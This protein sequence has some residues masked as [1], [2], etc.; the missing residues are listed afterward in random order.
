MPER[1]D[2]LFIDVLLGLLVFVGVSSSVSPWLADLYSAI[3]WPWGVGVV[4]I[5]VAGW[6]AVVFWPDFELNSEIR[7]SFKEP[8]APGDGR[9]A[10]AVRDLA[11][12]HAAHPEVAKELAE[13]MLQEKLTR[14]GIRPNVPP[15]PAKG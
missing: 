9:N 14:L 5:V 8:K 15:P 4:A 3:A 10:Q 6:A 11:A 13:R 1:R 12:K 7:E 2:M